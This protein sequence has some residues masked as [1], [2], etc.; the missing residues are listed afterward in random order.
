[1][2]GR[3]SSRRR[4]T[5]AVVV[6]CA[7]SAIV[8]VA[9]SAAG[10]APHIDSL[11]STGRQIDIRY[12]VS[13]ALPNHPYDAFI[14]RYLAF[15]ATCTSPSGTFGEQPQFQTDGSGSFSGTVSVPSQEPGVHIAMV[16]GDALTTP[17]AVSDISNCFEVKPPP[18]LSFATL[19][20][21]VGENAGFVALKVARSGDL[22]PEVTF[23]LGMST[24]ATRTPGRAAEG[25]VDAAPGPITGTIP[26]GAASVD[27]RWPIIDNSTYQG[28]RVFDVYFQESPSATT[29]DIATA[30][31][32]ADIVIVDD[33]AQSSPTT[34]PSGGGSSG[35]TAPSGG[36]V[37]PVRSSFAA[38]KPVKARKKLTVTVR[39]SSPEATAVDVAIV[40]WTR[41]TSTCRYVRAAGT[42]GIARN[43]RSLAVCR[44]K[45]FVSARRNRGTGQYTRTVLRGLPRGA[46]TVASR[47]HDELGAPEP[48]FGAANQRTLRVV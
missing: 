36:A 1:M 37:I 11:V 3:G 42:I 5:S 40:Q 31:Q 8:P 15:D 24:A 41:K 29:P 10:P 20:Y 39:V 38:L 46:Y 48:T 28:N 14:R 35:G 27:V 4:L 21:S 19:D 33:D 30:S 45:G 43:V 44:S 34:N 47:A 13:G 23:S 32:Q 25:G 9:A 17:E 26:A 22:A 2:P 12:S 18:A 7:A 6:G 16:L